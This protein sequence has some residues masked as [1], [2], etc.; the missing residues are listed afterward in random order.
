M[1]RAL[2]LFASVLHAGD[3]PKLDEIAR[4]ASVMVD[5]DVCQRILTER[6][7]QFILR[8]TSR[9]RWAD[10][11][12]YDVNDEAF[13]RT[14]KTLIR[15][16]QLTPEPVDVNL[17]MP[18]TPDLSRVHIVIRNRHEMSQFW[19]WGKLHQPMFREMR[20]VLTT[21]QR[22]T[23]ATKPGIVS[24]LAPVC[25]SLNEIVALVEVV[26]RRAPDLRENVK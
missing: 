2:L 26:S 4:V 19:E 24:I 12:N 25:N 17:W 6:A 7:K 10:A 15:L 16:A 9:D 20:T 1:T 11:D 14:K 18:L 21:G 22:L 5:G 13:T 8:S 23:V 3:T